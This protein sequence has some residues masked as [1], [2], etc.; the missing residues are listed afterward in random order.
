MSITFPNS[1]ALILSLFLLG[2]YL[3]SFIFMF[4][5][6]VVIRLY[7]KTKLDKKYVIIIHWEYCL[8]PILNTIATYASLDYIYVCICNKEGYVK[9]TATQF[10]ENDL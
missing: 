1:L 5:H 8:R 7:I 10:Y 3:L 2:I 9:N 4:I 6:E